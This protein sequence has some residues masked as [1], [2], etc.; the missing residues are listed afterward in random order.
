MEAIRAEIGRIGTM[1]ANIIQKGKIGAVSKS[2]TLT[3]EAV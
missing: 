2:G 1:P 3:Y